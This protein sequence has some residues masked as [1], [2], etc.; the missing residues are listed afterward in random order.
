MALSST[1]RDELSKIVKEG[2]R[3]SAALPFIRNLAEH[4]RI[5]DIPDAVWHAVANMDVN[6][7][8]SARFL[9]FRVPAI[10]VN[11]Y[12]NSKTPDE[13]TSIVQETLR[14]DGWSSRIVEA[15]TDRDGDELKR[16]IDTIERQAEQAREVA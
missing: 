2:S 9:A 8:L 15:V 14:D 16:V 11:N 6:R 1:E 13:F 3:A 5:M 4:K 10:I 12:W 7:T